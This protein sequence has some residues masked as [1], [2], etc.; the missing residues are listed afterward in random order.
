MTDLSSRQGS[1]QAVV[2]KAGLWR[3]QRGFSCI[4]LPWEKK[5]HQKTFMVK[6]SNLGIFMCLNSSKQAV[7]EVFRTFCLL[8]LIR[9]QFFIINLHSFGVF[10]LLSYYIFKI[11]TFFCRQL[12]MNLSRLDFCLIYS[13]GKTQKKNKRKRQ[14]SWE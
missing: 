13:V 9:I 3:R 2:R 4:H 5:I 7:T 6:T 11:Q 1:Q 8:L 10:I 14:R 12:W